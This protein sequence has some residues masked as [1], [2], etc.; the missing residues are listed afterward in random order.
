MA[1]EKVVVNAVHCLCTKNC[2]EIDIKNHFGRSFTE[3]RSIL[4]LGK[5]VEVKP[6]TDYDYPPASGERW[7]P[8]DW[9][10]E[11][12]IEGRVKRRT[13]IPPDQLSVAMSGER[14]VLFD[15]EEYEVGSEFG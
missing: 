9:L 12:D 11:F 4:Y 13:A 6:R 3:E 14:F 7:S 2:M 5:F 15:F 8:V 1:L 10:V